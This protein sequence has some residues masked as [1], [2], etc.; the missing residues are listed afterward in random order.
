MSSREAAKRK[1]TMNLHFLKS[2]DTAPE[3]PAILIGK[4]SKK[5][6]EIKTQGEM[7]SIEALDNE[8]PSLG[9]LGR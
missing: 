8:A 5:A 3:S 1:E 9:A 7:S 4:D 2:K 6:S